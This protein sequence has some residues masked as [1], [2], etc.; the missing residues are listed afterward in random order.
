[1]DAN[2]EAIVCLAWARMLGLDDAALVAAG[3]RRVEHVS[4]DASSLSFVSLFGRSVL[5]GPEWALA[6]A[7]KY[8]DEE[9]A[10]ARTLIQIA[11]DRCPRL[12][13]AA[14]LAFTDTYIKDP[15]LES[16][17]VT[18][19]PAA[20]DRL[21]KC[22]PPDDV[23]EV[24]LADLSAKFVLLGED[25]D[26]VAASGY[27]PWQGILAQVGVLTALDHRGRGNARVVS[28]IALNDALD[29]GMVPLW[30]A[31][32]DNNRARRVADALGFVEAGTETVVELSYSGGSC[33]PGS[34]A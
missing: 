12:V 13:S 16:A 28:A 26:V 29:E 14:T 10:A 22:C 24:G 31:R 5:V 17:V 20:L 2:T 27:R 21:E 23:A 25:D 8:P 7:E 18:D 4:P 9:L 19:D 6:A 32:A 30:R 33:P 11:R 1:M 34:S 3:D 15:A